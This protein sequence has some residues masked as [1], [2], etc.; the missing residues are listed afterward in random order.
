M[1]PAKI[2]FYPCDVMNR[3]QAESL[4][5]FLII[6]GTD[7]WLTESFNALTS[8][9]AK[10]ATPVRTWRKG[11]DERLQRTLHRA[12]TREGKPSENIWVMSRGRRQ[13]LS[14]VVPVHSTAPANNA[15]TITET[16]ECK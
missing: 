10:R 15:Q 1:R 13:R 7:E 5:A 6:D 12:P 14:E 8:E 2:F 4:G 11:N 3:D 9:L 16:N